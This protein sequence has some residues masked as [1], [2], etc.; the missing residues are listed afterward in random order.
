MSDPKTRMAWSSDGPE[1][2]GPPPATPGPKPAANPAP[3]GPPLRV[4]LERKGRGGK[5]VT[6][7]LGLTAHPAAIE[8]LARTLKARCGAGG[9]VRGK[10]IEIQG[11]ARDRVVALLVSLGYAAR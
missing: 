3:K 11:D 8:E 6:V 4:G 7:V 10:T 2:T 9:T 1:P 5:A